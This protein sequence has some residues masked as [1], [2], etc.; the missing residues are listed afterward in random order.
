MTT[1]RVRVRLDFE[2]ELPEDCS[3]MMLGEP[4]V[5]LGIVGLQK[6]KVMPDPMTLHG[7]MSCAFNVVTGSELKRRAA[8]AKREGRDG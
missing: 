5:K 2:V 7:G 8:R 3:P 1:T 4:L 6:A